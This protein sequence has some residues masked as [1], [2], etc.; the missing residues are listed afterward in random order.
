MMRKP[1]VVTVALL[2]SLT[3]GC[4]LGVRGAGE[5]VSETRMITSDFDS[6]E[7]R[8]SGD[9]V[10]EIGTE[11]S[12]VV[13][14]DSAV[15][16]LV[17]TV[18]EDG[19]LIIEQESTRWRG[20]DMLRISVTVPSLEQLEL[21]GS[22]TVSAGGLADTLVLD[23]SGSGDVILDGEV[24]RLDMDL[25][26][27]GSVD[28]SGVTAESVDGRGEGSGVVEVEVDGTL[29]EV[30]ID[31]S[32]S[33]TARGRVETASVAIAGSGELLARELTANV[34]DISVPGTGDV[35]ISAVD[36]LTATISGSGDVVYWGSP[37]LHED[38]S[39]SGTVEPG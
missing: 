24:D 16:D 13:E 34:V 29:L 25:A 19:R 8:G 9:L 10:V 39:G 4:G 2:M 3:A 21:S 31:G 23:L 15:I 33:V 14:T 22:G 6:V 26:G 7:L 27:D 28:A 30:S 1:T 18:V 12:V 36:R 32:M 38:I 11:P 17:T 35:A 37:E 20:V 5:V